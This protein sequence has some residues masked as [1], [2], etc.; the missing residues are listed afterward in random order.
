MPVFKEIIIDPSLQAS[1]LEVTLE[2]FEGS[3]AYFILDF[4][5]NKVV[6]GANNVEQLKALNEQYASDKFPMEKYSL[7]QALSDVEMNV[8]I[9][10]R[11]RRGKS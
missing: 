4:D 10:S 1:E 3:V 8:L 2:S 5:R 9:G 7:D 6:P 11:W